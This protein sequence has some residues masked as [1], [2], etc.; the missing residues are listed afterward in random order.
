MFAFARHPIIAIAALLLACHAPAGAQEQDGAG[1]AWKPMMALNPLRRWFEVQGGAWQ[2]PDAMLGDMAAEMR[3][4]A[5]AQVAPKLHRYIVQYQGTV[6]QGVR[7]IRVSGACTISGVDE[8]RLSQEFII[9]HDGGKCF[10]DA[11][12]DPEGRRFTAFHYHGY[13]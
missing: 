9:V 10:F 3:K 5:G 2:V 8:A 4:E 12:Y 1:P 13:A 6:A 7:A 11:T